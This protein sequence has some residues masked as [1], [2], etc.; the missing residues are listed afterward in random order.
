MTS[1]A[2]PKSQCGGMRN[3][4]RRR[5][6]HPRWHR[7]G[8]SS[9]SC[10]LAGLRA[11]KGARGARVGLSRDCRRSDYAS[12]NVVNIPVWTPDVLPAIQRAILDWDRV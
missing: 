3:A 8:S 1:R 4:W 10:A 2:R 7:A 6:G 11:E 9:P 12:H 5:C